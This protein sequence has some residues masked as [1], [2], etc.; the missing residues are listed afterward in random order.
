MHPSIAE[1]PSTE[2]YQG[3]LGH[4]V[5]DRL[6]IVGV[7]WPE[8]GECRVLMIDLGARGTEEQF[9]TSW[10][11]TV[12]AESALDLAMGI[13][14]AGYDSNQPIA[15]EQI[16]IIT[17]YAKQIQILQSEL[18]SRLSAANHGR[19]RTRLLAALPQ[20]RISTIDGF[21][22]AECDL[23]IFSMVRSNHD[24]QLGF[25]T[26]ERRANVLLSRARRG[27]VVLGDALT[28]R[29]ATNS[30]WAKWMQWAETR[31]A[32]TSLADVWQCLK[33]LSNFTAQTH[34][35]FTRFCLQCKVSLS[36]LQQQVV[37]LSIQCFPLWMM[38]TRE[39]AAVLHTCA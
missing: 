2:F 16:A 6:P 7:P 24:G 35:H 39:A 1:F 25:L 33:E 28:I 9:G 38:I 34:A 11:N 19:W 20:L 37:L 23:V 36:S 30:V 4:N 29:R 31:D 26:D 10:G 18:V 5:P 15:P 12:E 8:D 14:E 3:R 21:Q 32:V 22:G 27:L 17:P 13:L